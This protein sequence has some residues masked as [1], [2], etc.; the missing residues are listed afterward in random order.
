V[1]KTIPLEKGYHAG[2]EILSP[3]EDDEWWDGEFT[4]F[5]FKTIFNDIATSVPKTMANKSFEQTKWIIKSTTNRNEPVEW[6]E[7][8]I[9]FFS[10]FFINY[11][12]IKGKD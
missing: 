10:G 5:N 7:S 11:L 12:T 9:T 6:N 4:H 8:N 3:P 1:L 2:L